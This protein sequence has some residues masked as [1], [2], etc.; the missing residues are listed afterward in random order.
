MIAVTSQDL[1]DCERLARRFYRAL[2]RHEIDAALA[3]AAEDCQWIRAGEPK[4]GHDAMRAVMEARPR[5]VLARHLVCNAVAAPVANGEVEVCYD[6]LFLAAP[7]QVPD[8][9]PKPLVPPK[10]L[11]GVDRYRRTEGGWYLIYKRAVPE[12]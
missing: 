4:V 5:S 1:S 6:L 3:L 9:V 8:G 12:F 10:I 7:P 11:S 2:D